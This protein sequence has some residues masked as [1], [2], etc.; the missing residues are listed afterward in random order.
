M[1]KK[2]QHNP[3]YLKNTTADVIKHGSGMAVPNE[4]W[5]KNMDLTPKGESNGW[6]AF[7]PRCGYERPTPHVKTNECDH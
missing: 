5:E 4:Q 1:S 6:G 3:D 2:N 7:L